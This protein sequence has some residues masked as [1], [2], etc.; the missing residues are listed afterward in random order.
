MYANKTII[1]LHVAFVLLAYC[2]TGLSFLFIPKTTDPG[3]QKLWMASLVMLLAASGSILG[4]GL[5]LRL[6]GK[7][8]SLVLAVSTIA[9]F[10]LLL[11]LL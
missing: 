2:V 11:F 3:S 10:M 5:M 8:D 9:A 4:I 7:S 6:S 1:W